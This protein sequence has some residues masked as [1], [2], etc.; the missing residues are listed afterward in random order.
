MIEGAQCELW[1]LLAYSPDLNPIEMMWSKVKRLIRAAELRTFEELVQAVFNAM[2][3]VTHNNAA[4][5]FQHCGY[6]MPLR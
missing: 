2:D 5:F 3:A 4:G 6:S 1:M